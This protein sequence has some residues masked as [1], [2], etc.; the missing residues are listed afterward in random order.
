MEFDEPSNQLIGC[1]IE[2]HRILGPGLLEESC[3]QCLPHELRLQVEPL[4]VGV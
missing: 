4:S 3:N 1:A 2:V